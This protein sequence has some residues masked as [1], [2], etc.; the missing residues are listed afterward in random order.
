MEQF[1]FN[2]SERFCVFQCHDQWY[3]IP[4]LDVRGVSPRPRIRSVPNSDP[5]LCGVSHLHNKFIPIVSLQALAQI[6][7][8]Q[9]SQAQQELLTLLGPAG[10]WGVLI[11]Q[12][13]ALAQLEVSIS[14]F[15]NADDQWTK[16]LA[17]SASYR[18]Q[19]VQ[20]LDAKSLYQ[21]VAS[22]LDRFWQDGHQSNTQ[23]LVS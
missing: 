7:Y 19:V 11:D 20:I 2:G 13:I 5:F 8:Q 3:G 21:Y 9:D 18:N 10:P 15:K 22:M 12:V 4:A 16:V 23:L 14:N 1:D 17:G 6:N